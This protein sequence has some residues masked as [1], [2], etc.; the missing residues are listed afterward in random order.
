VLD[1]LKDMDIEHERGEVESSST[2]RDMTP[3]RR[4]GG[5]GGEGTSFGLTRQLLGSK[6]MKPRR[7]LWLGSSFF[8]PRSPLAV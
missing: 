1:P 8:T 7:T 6:P 3:V 4:R 5:A 2:G